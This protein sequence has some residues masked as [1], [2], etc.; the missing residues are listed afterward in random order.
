MESV[1]EELGCRFAAGRTVP[2][3]R[4]Y[5]SFSSIAGNEIAYKHTSED[6]TFAG[7]FCISGINEE[8]MTYDAKVKD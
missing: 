7:T 1:R 3:K 8:G 2:S 4:S 6:E 5:H